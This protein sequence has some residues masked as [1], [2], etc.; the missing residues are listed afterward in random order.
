[1]CSVAKSKSSLDVFVDTL[2]EFVF[3][4]GRGA[5]CVG[6]GV[7]ALNGKASGRPLLGVFGVSFSCVHHVGLLRA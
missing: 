5:V 1:M 7:C 2:Q 6:R 4:G 3:T